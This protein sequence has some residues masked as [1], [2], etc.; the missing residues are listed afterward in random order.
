V[1]AGGAV[2]RFQQGRISWHPSVGARVLRGSIA[3]AYVSFGAEGGPLGFPV[4]DSASVAGGTGTAVRLQRGRISQQT[5]A[6]AIPVHDALADAY[7]RAA[8]EDGPLGFPVAKEFAVAGGR[9]QVF[10]HGRVSAGPTAGAHWLSRR[11]AEKYVELGAESSSLGFPVTDEQEDA[12]WP[13]RSAANPTVRVVVFE[14]G[15][16]V[17][18]VVR[19]DVTVV[20]APA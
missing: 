18:D 15:S 5:G 1:V 2:T 10:E 16:I 11:I 3:L 19:D 17:W 13:W 4:A 7:Q 6:T 9:A 20:A 8:A 14:R 12:A